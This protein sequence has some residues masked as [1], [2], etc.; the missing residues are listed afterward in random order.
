MANT[1]LGLTRDQFAAFLQDHEQIKQFENLFALVDT[2]VA[3]NAVTEATILAG[4]AEASAANA[5][6]QIASIKQNLDYLVTIPAPQNNNSIAT[7]Y[8]DFSVTDLTPAPRIGRAFWD[9]GQTLN[10]QQTLNVAGKIN[11]DNFYYIKAD[12]T[13]TKGQLV[14]F[15]GSV[16]AS[17]VLKGAPA[18]GLGVNDG[19]RLMGIAAEN[20]ATND[21]GM[22]QWSGVLRGFDTTGSSVGEIWADG[23]ILYY[24]PAYAGGLTKNEPVAPNVRAVIA[25]VVTAGSSG[26]GSVA[27]RLSVGSVL[28]GTDSNVYINGLTGG[29]LLQ[30]DGTDSRWENIAASS[31]VVG[32]A[33]NIAGGSANQLV[34]QTAPSTTSFATVGSGLLLSGGTLSNSAPDQT[35]TLTAGTG[36]SVSGTYPN[37]TITN[38]APDQTVSLTGAG[39]T[40]VTGTYPNFTITSNDAFTGTVTS[41]AATAGTGISV[42]GSPITTSGTLTITNTA[43]D[44]TVV[45]TQ[46]GTTTITGTYPNF[47]ISSADQYDGTVTSV[48][49]TGSVN[50]ITLSGTVTSSGSLTLGGTLTGVDLTSQVTGTLPVGNGGTGTATAFTAG[51][52]VFAGASGVYSQDNA[53]FFWDDT[54][55]KLGIGNTNPGY[56]VDVSSSDTSAGIG[57]AF[58]LRSNA[59]AAAASVQFTDSGATAQNG[60][61]GVN[62][63]GEM[64]LQADGGSSAIVFYL[65][66]GAERFRVNASGAFGLGG[67]NY[68]TSGQVLSSQGSGSSPAWLS[69][70]T[71]ATSGSFSDLSNKPGIRSNG[72]NVIAGSK[73]LG[74]ADSGTNI[75]IVASGITITFPSTGFA[76]GEG[77]AISNVSGG[78]VTLS[79]PGGADFGS[80]LPNNGTFFAFCDGGGFWR[81]YCYSTSRL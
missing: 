44:Q 9:G 65:N 26:S 43:P 47:T 71:V 53:N 80:T 78:N 8:I 33:T 64:K 49:G 25:A 11:E 72:Q 39:T 57:Y 67:A 23:D 7:D 22:V 12:S 4:T 45:L 69:L 16:G 79:A 24:N 55:N 19:V 27:I 56:A 60:V 81:Q 74:S 20:I 46:G 58:R 41:V 50:G 63:S 31:V 62:D 61:I 32:T 38:S 66:T 40:V 70:A 10:V 48:S 1:K 77:F 75:L 5:L 36:I 2:E 42:S 6:A 14:M 59:T 17:G 21:F 3:P 76:S 30:Y 51:S 54:N 13:I 29:D 18:I 28:G 73:T 52:V 34:Y 68:G 35:V 15:T 37:F